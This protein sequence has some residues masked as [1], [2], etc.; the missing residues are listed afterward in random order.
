MPGACNYRLDPEGAVLAN[1]PERLGSGSEVQGF[2]V[3]IGQRLLLEALTA[4]NAAELLN[5]FGV[6][7]SSFGNDPVPFR[8]PMAAI[9]YQI[10]RLDQFWYIRHGRDPSAETTG[11][12]R[13][14]PAA[15]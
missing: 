9:S 12:D 13:P 3:E 6:I 15:R 4:G 14:P 10:A 8:V 2:R 5:R 7:S 11:L 1:R